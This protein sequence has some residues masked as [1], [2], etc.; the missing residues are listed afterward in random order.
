MDQVV[1]GVADE[2]IAVELGRV[3]AAAV[4]G[5]ARPASTT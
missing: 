3:G 2:G 5:H 1:L 4:D